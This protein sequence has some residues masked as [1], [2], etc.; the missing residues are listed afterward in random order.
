[1]GWNYTTSISN[2]SAR[3]AGPVA[4]MLDELRAGLENVDTTV[5]SFF[6]ESVLNMDPTSGHNHDG[7]N[8]KVLA[9]ATATKRGGLLWAKK[10]VEFSLFADWDG[11]GPAHDLNASTGITTIL[12]ATVMWRDPSDVYQEGHPD[13][14]S[15]WTN[16]SMTRNSAAP[17]KG[18]DVLIDDVSTPNRLFVFHEADVDG[19][20]APFGAVVYQAW[21]I[22]L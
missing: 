5:V 1:M 17:F 16:K 3:N 19:S 6:T 13:A 12:F 7:V 15:A 18:Y 20:I 10:N 9:S 11:G 2:G 21:I 8:S 22:G 14:P 4:I